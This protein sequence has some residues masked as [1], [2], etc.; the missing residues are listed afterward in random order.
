MAGRSDGWHS[1]PPPAAPDFPTDPAS[2][3]LYTGG[4]GYPADAG[5]PADPP[6]D[7]NYQAGYPQ[8]AGYPQSAGY[9]EGAYNGVGYADG[10]GTDPY[11]PDGYEGYRPR[12]A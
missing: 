3:Y 10:Y 8:P 7:A 2:H 1:A 5:Y 12:Q 11:G 6:A 9:P 4:S